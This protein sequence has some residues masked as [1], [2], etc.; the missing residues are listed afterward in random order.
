MLCKGG[1]KLA[2]N[3]PLHCSTATPLVSQVPVIC[4]R[5]LRSQ[6]VNCTVHTSKNMPVCCQLHSSFFQPQC[7]ITVQGVPFCLP[8]CQ[9]SW[10]WHTLFCFW[11]RFL[12]SDFNGEYFTI[13]MTNISASLKK[14]LGIFPVRLAVMWLAQSYERDRKRD[15]SE[16]WDESGTIY[17]WSIARVHL[18]TFIN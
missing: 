18:S 2:K 4:Q 5:Q 14:R 12:W 16:F 15:E 8:T 13:K 11:L 6:C 17:Y 3:S 1:L 7:F 10:Q 9:T